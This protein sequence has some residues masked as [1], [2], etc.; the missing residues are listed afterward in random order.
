MSFHLKRE[1]SR[2]LTCGI[3]AHGFAPILP[4]VNLKGEDVLIVMAS[5]FTPM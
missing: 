5:H 3:L 2:Y 1:F 4:I